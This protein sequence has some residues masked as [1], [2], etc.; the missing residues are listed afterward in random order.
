LAPP[1]SPAKWDLG[2]DGRPSWIGGLP[3]SFWTTVF[4]WEL[5]FGHVMRL[6]MPTLL[7]AVNGNG[8]SPVGPE[9][10]RRAAGL[11]DVCRCDYEYIA[12]HARTPADGRLLARS[13]AKQRV[14]DGRRLLN[15]AGVLPWVTFED[16]RL[17]KRWWREGA[18]LDSLEEWQQQPLQDLP[19]S[20]VRLTARAAGLAVG[21]LQRDLGPAA[22]LRAWRALA[23]S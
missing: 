4:E 11:R 3:G 2:P 15:A 18:F 5:G 6:E 12:R 10:T 1:G 20:V 9:A 8:T 13:T 23:G 21:R 22:A 17:P 7:R 19:L 14:R 16:G